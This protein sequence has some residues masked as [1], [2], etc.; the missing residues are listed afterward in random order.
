M[1]PSEKKIAYDIPLDLSN[2][3]VNYGIASSF[4]CPL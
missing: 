2:P 1:Q 3:F 4:L